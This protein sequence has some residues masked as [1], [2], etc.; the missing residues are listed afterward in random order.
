MWDLSSPTRDGTHT[1]CIGKQNLSQ[2]NIRQG[3]ILLFSVETMNAIS[4]LYL[5]SKL[6]LK[7]TPSILYRSLY[8]LLS[9]PSFYIYLF[10]PSPGSQ[11]QNPGY[12]PA[13]QSTRQGL[14]LH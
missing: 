12:L 5:L 10:S 14:F 4:F 7:F 13:F 1:F 9:I 8:P 6:E 11:G 3:P 2:Q